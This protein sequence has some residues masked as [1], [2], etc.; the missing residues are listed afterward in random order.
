MAYTEASDNETV[1][2]AI[3]FVNNPRGFFAARY[4][5]YRACDHRQLASLS[6][7]RFHVFIARSA[8]MRIEPHTP[9]HNGKVE[10]YN[11]ILAEELLY[12]RGHTSGAS[13]SKSG[14]FITI[15]TNRVQ[16]AEERPP[17]AYRR[18][19]VTNVRA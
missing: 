3:D 9:K 1:A 17:A 2:T 16:H 8:A 7:N 10:R 6:G 18:H 15:A 12:S 5:P 13:P 14:M 4:R 19:R 11:R